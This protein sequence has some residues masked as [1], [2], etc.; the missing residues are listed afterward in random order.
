[1][2]LNCAFVDRINSYFELCIHLFGDV[3]VIL[4]LFFFVLNKCFTRGT[5]KTYMLDIILP[6][7]YFFVTILF[8][9]SNIIALYLE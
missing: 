9:I 3:A 7:I 6:S 1:M 8:W 5:Q 4:D 2:N